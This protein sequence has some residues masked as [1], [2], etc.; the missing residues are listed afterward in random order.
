MIDGLGLTFGI[1]QTNKET[2]SERLK[3]E[4]ISMIYLKPIL[5]KQIKKKL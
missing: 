3:T 4:S 5:R 1:S 2:S